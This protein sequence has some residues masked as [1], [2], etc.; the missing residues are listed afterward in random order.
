MAESLDMGTD[1]LEDAYRV[2]LDEFEGPLDLLLHL[3]KKNEINIYDIPIAVIAKQYLDYISLMKYLNLEVAGEFLV[4]AATLIHIK[5]RM[6][7]PVEADGDE[8][9]D[10]EDPRAELVRRLLEYK[11]F[12]E[13]AADLVERGQQWRDVFGRPAFF[14]TAPARRPDEEIDGTPLELTLFD[15]VDAFQ[16]IVQRTPVKAFV[17]V[18]SDH[19]TVK[20]RMNYILERLADE[21]AIP[22]ESLFVPEEGRLVVI[23]TFLGLLEL[24]RIQLVRAYQAEAFGAILLSRA[25]LPATAEDA[26]SEETQP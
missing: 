1:R 11:Q 6:L 21:P 7:L 14:E 15:L 20:D 22:F 8:D 18:T 16:D 19:L 3:I 24:V 13:A 17:D 2:R 5:S 23:V 25:F 10:G 4:M 12:K 26:E 9:E